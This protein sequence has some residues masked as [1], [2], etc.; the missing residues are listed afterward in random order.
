MTKKLSA[1]IINKVIAPPE[2]DFETVAQ[3]PLAPLIVRLWKTIVVLGG[4]ALLV[5]LIW[6]AID[7]IMSEGD[8]EKL[9]SARLKIT[10]AMAGM[11]ILAAS[12]AI[13]ALFKNFFGFDILNFE[14]PT[15]GE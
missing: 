2:G 12:Y 6:G 14:W 1:A 9:K 8:Q 13:I 7:W 11:A 10:H 4:L 5:F 3:N 15:P